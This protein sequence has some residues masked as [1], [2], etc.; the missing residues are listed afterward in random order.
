MSTPQNPRTPEPH[1]QQAPPTKGTGRRVPVW[2]VAA[3]AGVLL[4]AAVGGGFALGTVQGTSSG[5]SGT[6]DAS[7]EDPNGNGSGDDGSDGAGGAEDSDPEEAGLQGQEIE[8]YGIGFTLPE[9]WVPHDDLPPHASTELDE[10]AIE[11]ALLREDG[12]LLAH[13]SLS[14]MNVPEEGDGPVGTTGAAEFIQQFVGPLNEGFEAGGTAPYEVEGAV[15][16]ARGDFVI[17]ETD[18]ASLYVDTG[19]EQYAAVFVGIHDAAE[20]DE[21][22]E[23]LR[24]AILESVHVL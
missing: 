17:Q 24:E 3:G 15:E 9:D 13:A 16:A 6:E 19:G 20:P 7:A 18:N 14:A 4:L 1:R 11:H 5:G 2:A 22:D 23:E 21:A 8:G 12:T 10:P